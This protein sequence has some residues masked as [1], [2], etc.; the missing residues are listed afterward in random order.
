MKIGVDGGALSVSDD[1]L[2][3]GVYTVISHLLA[4]LGEKDK[5]NTYELYSFDPINK[6]LLDSFGPSMDNKVLWPAKGWFRVRLPL[7][8][9]LHPVN[10]FLGVSQAIP[11]TR[12]PA[13][14]F[15]YD[16]GFLHN[17]ESY[18]GSYAKLKKQTE[19]LV[20]RS[21]KIITISEYV[22]DDIKKTY[23]YP[24]DDIVVA[25]PGLDQRFT[26]KSGVHKGSHPYFLFV[27][28]LKVGKNVPNI[29]RAFAHFLKKE[30]KLFDLYLVG[31]DFWKDPEIDRVIAELNLHERVHKLGFVPD[32]DLPAL[33]RGAVALVSPSLHEGFCIPALEAMASGC[34][35]I[36]STTGAMP[37]IVGQCGTLVNPLDVKAIADAL[38]V[39]AYNATQR[40]LYSKKG[41]QQ[42]KKYTWKNFGDSILH[43]IYDTQTNL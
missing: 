9:K 19:Q 39:M 3:V 26:E 23:G 21:R 32:D 12:I 6:S 29:I 42:A 41:L 36:G 37:E 25:Y 28:A 2:K 17:P 5:K 11:Q 4:Q 31:G 16:L 24:S 10:L 40:N 43:E 14:G 38:N 8:L 20:K 18:K 34:P 7:E 27:G 13:I 1:R 22:K 35:V 30:K 33:Y 15:I